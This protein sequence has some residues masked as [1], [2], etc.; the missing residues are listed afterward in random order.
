MHKCTKCGSKNVKVKNNTGL[1][2]LLS[3]LAGRPKGQLTVTC[4]DCGH[5]YMVMA[6]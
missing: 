2:S 1:P 5:V 6:D 3:N 4:K